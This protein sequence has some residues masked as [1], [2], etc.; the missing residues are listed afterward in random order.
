MTLQQFTVILNGF[1][2]ACT[3]IVIGGARKI[4]VANS[5]DI[6]SFSIACIVMGVV[7]S[8]FIARLK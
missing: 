1:L 2:S 7:I 5:V 6:L 3:Q 4:I 8:F